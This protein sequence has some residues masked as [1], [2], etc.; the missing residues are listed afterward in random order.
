MDNS[1]CP[2]AMMI[3]TRGNCSQVVPLSQPWASFENIRLEGTGAGG[4]FHLFCSAMLMGHQIS[5]I[6]T[7]T[8]V[9]C[10]MRRALPLD[11]CTPLMFIHQKYTV[12]RTA[13]PA[14]NMLTST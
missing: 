2:K 1:E 7:M 4:S 13:M 3:I 12:T 10:M 11:S 5:R 8:V 9:I 6:A 14:E